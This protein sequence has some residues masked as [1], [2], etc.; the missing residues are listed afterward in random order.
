MAKEKHVYTCTECGAASLKW[1]GKC[2]QCGSWDTL[3]EHVYRQPASGTEPTEVTARPLAEIPFESSHQLWET[4]VSQ[5]DR[6]LGGGI[7]ASS[8]GLLGGTPGVGKSTLILQMMSRIGKLGK[9]VLYVSGEESESQI[10]LRSL[11]LGISE[12]NI[13]LL[14]SGGR[15]RHSVRETAAMMHRCA[16]SG[17]PALLLIGHVTKEGTIAGPKVL[18]H[19]VDYVIYMETAAEPVYRYLYPVKNRYGSLQETG[20]FKMTAKGLAEVQNLN[21]LFNLTQASALPGLAYFAA[22]EGSRMIVSEVQAL[23]TPESKSFALGRQTV[24][25]AAACS[26]SRRLSKNISAST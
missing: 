10:K 7:V 13:T 9:R 16:K 3:T 4:G 14:A 6:V 12:D 11:R 25:T 1:T 24:L 15:R 8:V 19:L 22:F 2:A 17:G 20:I 26:C 5:F 21:R 23:V 18:E